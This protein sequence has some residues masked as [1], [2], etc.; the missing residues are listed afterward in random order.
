[1]NVSLGLTGNVLQDELW[2]CLV[3]EKRYEFI[4]KSGLWF[5][6]K[7]ECPTVAHFGLHLHDKPV[8]YSD[9]LS[10]GILTDDVSD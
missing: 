2:V 10:T 6:L 7:D 8:S 5:N 3:C 1:M 4:M 9:R